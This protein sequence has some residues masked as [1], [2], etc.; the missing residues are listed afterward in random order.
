MGG[1]FVMLI[2][3]KDA[4]V[5]LTANA[6]STQD[7][8]NLVHNYL[9]PAIKSDKPLPENPDL[10]SVLRKKEASL[11]MKRA[12]TTESK[13]E[14]ISKISGKEF[15]F[16]K[17]NFNIQSVWFTF[18]GKECSFALKR[19]DNLSILKSGSDKWCISNVKSSSL[20]AAPR[21]VSKSIDANYKIL[22]PVIKAAAT[23]SWTDNNTL[24]LTARFIEESLGS[25]TII[26]KFS[27]MAG[28]VN[29]SIEQKAG[30]AI[31]GI[32][33]ASQ[34]LRGTLLKTE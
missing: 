15:D 5:V 2:P 18:N 27:E 8:L 23:Y 25:E 24:E 28:S 4:I 13:S 12:E 29:V 1:Q 9:I 7:E 6:K 17:N 31:M 34:P 21:P 20:L 3:D 32:A 30:G 26:C 14:F 33:G 11:I 19:E 22:L 16:G 10:V